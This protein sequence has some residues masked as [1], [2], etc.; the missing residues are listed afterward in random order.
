MLQ[1]LFFA[2]MIKKNYLNMN[3]ECRT[4]IKHIGSCR[5]CQHMHLVKDNERFMNLH[6]QHVEPSGLVIWGR[7]LK[8]G[9]TLFHG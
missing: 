5:I 3:C 6:V 7:F 9:I 4:G 2:R 8:G 1:Y